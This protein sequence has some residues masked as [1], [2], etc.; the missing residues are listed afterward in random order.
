MYYCF[1][2]FKCFRDKKKTKIEDLINQRCL[3]VHVIVKASSMLIIKIQ[4]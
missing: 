4:L 2:I 3:E 1:S